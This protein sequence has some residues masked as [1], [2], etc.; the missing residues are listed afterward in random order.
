MPYPQNRSF[1]VPVDSG[2][3]SYNNRLYTLT[4]MRFYGKRTGSFSTAVLYFFKEAAELV[5]FHGFSEGKPLKCLKSVSF[6]FKTD[7]LDEIL[8]VF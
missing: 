3:G 5:H 2:T 8:D 6:C 7:C 1:F 4:V